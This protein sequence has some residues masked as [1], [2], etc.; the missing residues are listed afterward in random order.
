MEGRV[1]FRTGPA[2]LCRRWSVRGEPSPQKRHRLA[3]PGGTPG[4]SARPGGPDLRQIC[5]AIGRPPTAARWVAWA[6][7]LF[8]E[9]FVPLVLVLLLY[10]DGRLPSRRWRPAV[11]LIV[12]ANAL[13]LVVAATS[14]VAFDAA[15]PAG[16]AAPLAL[17]PDRIADPLVNNLEVMMLF[18][19]LLSAAG[20][21]VRY[22]RAGG[23][24]RQQIKWFAYAGTVAAVGF[25]L[26]ASV[27]NDPVI[28]FIVLVPLIPV[29]A[30]IAIMKY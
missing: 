9:A 4:G 19:F 25:V 30:G 2:G 29:A 27:S 20:C 17:I 1:R 11:W 23:V 3:V 26:L 5:G 7:V 8:I 15:A 16:L 21:V 6:A 14:N 12:G 28:A 24:V 22:R 18:L 10:P 13:L